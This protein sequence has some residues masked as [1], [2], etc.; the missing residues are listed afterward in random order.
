MRRPDPTE[1]S[2]YYSKYVALVVE[3]DILA[4]MRSQ[5]AE[6]LALL[7]DLPDEQL[8]RRHPPYTW[9]I[10][11]VVGHLIDT[12][13]IFG[14]RALRFARGDSTPLSGFD[15]S[16]YAQH[17][18]FDRRTGADLLAELETVRRSHVLL[19]ENLT[20]SAW[21]RRGL[22]SGNEFSVRALA[23]MIVGHERHHVGIVRQRLSSV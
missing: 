16:P 8:C 21:D 18:E 20:D 12:E 3:E 10:K 11:Q 2:R 6:S 23:Y 7:R 9:S 5:L 13:R 22:A 14:Y 19:F 15:E 1:Y 17:G 4:A